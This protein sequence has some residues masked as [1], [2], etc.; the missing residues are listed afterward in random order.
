[1]IITSLVILLIAQPSLGWDAE[2][3][4]VIARMVGI[5]LG[6]KANSFVYDHLVVPTAERSVKGALASA[7]V[8]ADD[9]GRILYP[10]SRK[11][12]YS[13][14]EHQQCRA[15]DPAEDCGVDKSGPCLV[16]GID[17]YAQRAIDISLT[18]AERADAIRF[19]LHLLADAHQPL[20][21]GFREDHG[22]NEIR[23]Q[24]AEPS[25]TT[26]TLP[27]NLH[28]LWDSY[29]LDTYRLNLG[30]VSGKSWWTLGQS[31]SREFPD[32]GAFGMHID[33]VRSAAELAERIVSET[34][35]EVT[36]ELAYRD[37]GGMF[38]DKSRLNI[39]SPAYVAR[40]LEVMKRQFMRAAVRIAR[41]LDLA[42]LEY[43]LAVRRAIPQ[44]YA[45]WGCASIYSALGEGADFDPEE[46]AYFVDTEDSDEPDAAEGREIEVGQI[47]AA[48]AP[49]TDRET[50]LVLL[51][52][53]DGWYISDKR[54]VT[55]DKFVPHICRPIRLRLANGKFFNL[56]IDN[57]LL[58]GPKMNRL[59]VSHMICQFCNSADVV[60][61]TGDQAE[62]L[63]VIVAPLDMLLEKLKAIV[64]V[65]LSRRFQP[66]AYGECNQPSQAALLAKYGEK[67][68][69]WDDEYVGL[70][71]LIEQDPVVLPFAG[72]KFVTTKAYLMDYETLQWVVNVIP[73][74]DMQ[75]YIL[76]DVRVF[77]SEPSQRLM[78]YVVKWG[79]PNSGYIKKLMDD[80]PPIAALINVMDGL[81][82]ESRG[83]DK[84]TCIEMIKRYAKS[85][86]VLARNDRDYNSIE[87]NLRSERSRRK[88]DV[89]NIRGSVK[90]A[91]K[92]L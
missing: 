59:A 63:L 82:I 35:T 10:N 45:E 76:F 43:Y 84:E 61:A 60:S 41:V 85:I 83:D 34:A 72:F 81:M 74:G 11:L 75:S 30:A 21:V 7:S 19:V 37:E 86:S 27:E 39:I 44:E 32:T 68:R 71:L 24:L 64:K 17:E 12:H 89:A 51:R 70:R 87:S 5:L 67:A 78:D 57:S 80:P 4:R 28:K 48:A 91:K 22:G 50:T 92:I 18:V 6:K 90:D 15:Y 55:S 52:R 54:F 33:S 23:I 14:T 31:I 62:D 13:F 8:W 53:D 1:M 58:S 36:C 29:L 49:R 66:H 40:S 9:Q 73:L 65:N 3:H 77:N 20:H 38:F 42:A 47:A 25:A 46:N 88:E 26:Q 79:S 16:T 56:S 2:G 69:E